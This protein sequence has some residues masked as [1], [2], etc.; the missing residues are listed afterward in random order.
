MVRCTNGYISTTRRRHRLLDSVLRE[1]GIA[2]PCGDEDRARSY[3]SQYRA[4]VTIISETRHEQGV[5]VVD[6][7]ALE[8]AQT[9]EAATRDGGANAG[10]NGG[11]KQSLLAAAGMADHA[12]ARG[13]DVR[14]SLEIIPCATCV[15][16]TL[17]REARPF[18]DAVH[19]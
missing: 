13:I 7:I 15:P 11:G 18:R 16:D 10:V 12:Q 19:W 4:V 1:Y 2:T 14:P 8:R 9:A 5:V 3:H 6:P 17:T